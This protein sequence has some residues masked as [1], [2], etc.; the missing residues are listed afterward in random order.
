M[1]EGK[2]RNAVT[3]YKFHSNQ[4]SLTMAMR[5][6]NSHANVLNDNLAVEASVYVL[7]LA[8]EQKTHTH[9]FRETDDQR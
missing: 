1:R 9:A 3:R 8:N 7:L 2:L 5:V 6:L 4:E